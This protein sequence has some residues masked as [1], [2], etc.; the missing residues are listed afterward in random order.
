MERELIIKIGGNKYVNHSFFRPYLYIY[1]DIMVYTKRKHVFWVDEITMPYNHIAQVNLH[2]GIIFSK[3]EIVLSGGSNVVTVKGIWNRPAK[4]TKKIID[5]K[6]YHTHNK[7]NTHD[8]SK[9]NV[10]ESVERSLSRLKELHRKEK[11]SKKEFEKRRAQ[12]LSD[13]HE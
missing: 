13:L 1:D 7:Q 5:N 11:I 4:R 6:V 9:L 12:I 2:K 10:V 8:E 3:L